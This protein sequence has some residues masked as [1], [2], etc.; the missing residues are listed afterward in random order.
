MNSIDLALIYFPVPNVIPDTEVLFYPRDN[1][2]RALH[3]MWW[4]GDLILTG[5][6]HSIHETTSL[7]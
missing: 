1:V 7:L 6:W 4:C 5:I 2:I 3:M